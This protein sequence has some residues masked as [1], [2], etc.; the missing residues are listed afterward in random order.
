M[1]SMTLGQFSNALEVQVRVWCGSV[2]LQLILMFEDVEEAE[3]AAVDID[4]TTPENMATRWYNGKA[5][6]IATTKAEAVEIEVLAPS[7]PPPSPPLPSPPPISPPAPPMAPNA[8]WQLAADVSTTITAI[9][10]TTIAISV[11][12]SILSGVLGGGS[13]GGNIMPLIMGAQR[14]V[15]MA[16]AG[17]PVGDLRLRV[18]EGL[19]WTTG[20][21]PFV[22]RVTFVL[23]SEVRR[24]S[25][26]GTRPLLPVELVALVNM[27]I[28][29]V[30]AFAFTL[31]IQTGIVCVWRHLVNRRYH[32]QQR[33]IRMATEANDAVALKRAAEY[34]M[35]P[36]RCCWGVCGPK[37]KLR[38]PK[39]F[40]FPKSL[41]WPAPL[42]FTFCIFVTGLIRS[43][44]RL[45]A[46]SPDECNHM[47]VCRVLPACVFVTL[48]MLLGL[49]IVD[50]L[51]FRQR[52]GK[53][54]RWK[55]ANKHATP[56]AV[57]DP[58]M[59][60][61]AKMRVQTM[62][63]GMLAGDRAIRLGIGARRSLPRR[64][65]RA[66]VVPVQE[67]GIAGRVRPNIDESE[68]KTGNAVD[69]QRQES[70]L[71]LNTIQEAALRAEASHHNEPP[72]PQAFPE[73]KLL[74]G[75]ELVPGAGLASMLCAPAPTKLQSA[76]PSTAPMEAT[77]A[78]RENGTP[79]CSVLVDEMPRLS[80]RSKSWL[81]LLGDDATTI[82]DAPSPM[83]P[84]PMPASFTTRPQCEGG[85]TSMLPTPPTWSMTNQPMLGIA[86]P[87][88]AEASPTKRPTTRVATRPATAATL[89]RAP[90]LVLS[91]RSSAMMLEIADPSDPFLDADAQ[92]GPYCQPWVLDGNRKPR[93]E[94]R[95][96]GR[97]IVAG[98]AIHDRGAAEEAVPT[99]RANK[100]EPSVTHHNVAGKLLLS[101]RSHR[102]MALIDGSQE[103]PTSL[104]REIRPLKAVPAIRGIPAN[105]APAA[106][107][108]RS[109]ASMPLPTALS[110]RSQSL[111]AIIDDVEPPPGAA[112]LPAP[113]PPSRPTGPTPHL[114]SPPP[115]P[116]PAVEAE[117]EGESM[118]SSRL[119]MARA[120]ARA[121]DRLSTH[122]HRDRKSGA[123]GVPE[124][125]TKEPERTERLLAS[126]FSFNRQ[127][128]GDKFQSIEGFLL[129]R[130]HGKSRVGAGYRFIVIFVNI[131]FGIV[132]GVQP[133]IPVGSSYALT[134]TFL[135]L[136]LQF[137]MSSIC[138]YFLPDADRI[139]SRFAGTQFLLEGLSSTSLL[140]AEHRVRELALAAMTAANA[141]TVVNS[142]ALQWNEVG[143]GLLEFGSAS[144]EMDVAL[145]SATNISRLAV[146][147]TALDTELFGADTV[148]AAYRW[149][150]DVQLLGFL[151]SL[152]A[153]AVPM[154][155]LLEQRFCTPGINVIKAKGGNPL[156]LLAA[157]YMLAVSLPRQISNLIA[158]AGSGGL[159]AATS[160]G[161]ASADA[162][163][164]AME[165]GGETDV[166]AQGGGDD[167]KG[168]EIELSG[169]SVGDAAAKTARLLARAVAAKE[170]ASKNMPAPVLVDAGADDDAEAFSGS[171]APIHALYM[172][173]MRFAE[174][175]RTNRVS[176]VGRAKAD[177]R[178]DDV[179]DGDNDD[180]GGDDM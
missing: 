87:N 10:S 86:R 2:V 168:A 164:E 67:G 8:Q 90:S 66:Y 119:S 155:Q 131:I 78:T 50:I 166:D 80:P 112:R 116:S 88:T 179:D 51:L 84:I 167:P 122:G 7:P 171:R 65:K 169:E 113:R 15:A 109:S 38:A 111:M 59:R 126:P 148:I 17:V 28:T 94:M 20:S 149:V 81:T 37:R 77:R 170:A 46:A 145:T 130:V 162:G 125:D 79:L 114:P 97:A 117:I 159:D 173:K 144:L 29:S 141:T 41:V 140:V 161:S 104:P 24:L 172:A 11:V 153:M 33:D 48:T 68:Q 43:S 21:L 75:E 100:A 42:Y 152:L 49:T 177:A 58:Y 98:I 74:P 25:E 61:R 93:D 106:H 175:S 4:A 157:A 56:S 62:A 138:F 110:P 107:R 101:P 96:A 6:I 146:D 27:L 14:F 85:Y 154:I 1:R 180:D 92:I 91:P 72:R 134:Q 150:E 143:S 127:R 54:I 136:G 22:D 70:P 44:V 5:T 39:F 147:A 9:I 55:P 53:A 137:G 158:S 178:N 174:Q 132:S 45:L 52:H 121:F 129:F 36:E 40:P 123:F 57:A 128:I 64:S 102:L 63:V 69:T 60:L 108:I 115:S 105:T 163:D 32:R 139:I 16:D 18:G 35:G 89:K 99:S 118:K 19:E 124:D 34:D 76:R 133:L 95:R 71:F 135:I 151:F 156:A 103:S 23:P 47:P 26:D 142:T 165:T 31:V 3:V 160:A 13:G 120:R 30:V 73:Q 12:A 82:D 83:T 176:A